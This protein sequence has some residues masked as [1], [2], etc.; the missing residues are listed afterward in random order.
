[1]LMSISEVLE[2]SVSTLLGETVTETEAGSLRAISEKLEVINLQLARRKSCA[3][4]VIHW[5]FIALCAAVVIVYAVL[6]ALNSPYIGWD[7]SDPETAVLGTA[8]HVFEW[9][10][11]RAAPIVLMAA[12]AG[13]LLTR[14][15]A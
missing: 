1:M 14:K 11:V 5:S 9:T 2:T 3:R 12:A 13:A 10:Y 7:Y 6:A 8:F 15:K 4:K